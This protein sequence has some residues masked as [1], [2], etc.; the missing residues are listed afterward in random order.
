VSYAVS[1]KTALLTPVNGWV[2]GP[3]STA[4]P[5]AAKI[6]GIVYF[7][8]AI[9][10]SGSDPVAFRLPFMYR[11]SS[12]VYL[13]VDMCDASNGRL[14][15]NPDGFVTVQAEDGVFSNAQRFTSLDGVSYLP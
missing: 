4:E 13:P 15:I 3:F 1:A 7:R 10:A 9:S 14:V 8:G 6:N 5:A 11:P 12:D 2:G